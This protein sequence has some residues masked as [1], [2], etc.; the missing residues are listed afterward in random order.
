MLSVVVFTMVYAVVLP[1]AHV[2]V[3]AR[4]QVVVP[5]EVLGV[6]LWVWLWLHLLHLLFSWAGTM[7][8]GA[9]PCCNL[10]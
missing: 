10:L 4:M 8:F 9:V 2:V 5:A 7:I 3:L 6:V 1:G